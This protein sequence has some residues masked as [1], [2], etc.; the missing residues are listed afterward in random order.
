MSKPIIGIT[1]DS[2]QPGGYS[3]YKW[4]ALREHYADVIAACG[5][6]PLP[7][8]HYEDLSEEFGTI[9]HGLLITGGGFDVPP[10]LYGEPKVHD[11]VKLNERRSLFE[12]SV[13]RQMMRFQKPC[14]GICGGMQL[15]NVL[16]GGGLI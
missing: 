14:L 2:Q 1:L 3:R 13:V 7:L 11:T 6:I 10:H 12:I 8:T 9:I 4:Y 15:L 16:R 5:G